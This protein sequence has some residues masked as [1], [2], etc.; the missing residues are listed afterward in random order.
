[1]KT[2]VIGAGF[3][4]LAAA[5]E[6]AKAGHQVVV[7]EKF[8]KAG[9][10][11]AGFSA[12][13]WRWTAEHHYHHIFASDHHV[14]NW[15]ERLELADQV[16]F[17]P[18]VSA[19]YRQKQINRLDSPVS[20]LLHPQLSFM[21]KL[22]TAAGLGFCKLRPNGLSLERWT[23]AEFIQTVMGRESW[24][25]LWQPL[26]AGKF[27][28]AADQ[29]N[30]AWFWA[31]IHTRSQRLGY[32]KGGF[33]RLADLAVKKLFDQGVKF[34]F[35]TKV[36][37]IKQTRSGW[38]LTA[39]PLNSKKTAVNQAGSFYFDQVLFTGHSRELVQ[40]S[41][42]LPDWYQ[43]QLKKLTGLGAVSLLLEL[44]EPLLPDDTYWLNINQ[45][46]WPFLAVVEHTNLVSPDHYGHK[47]LVYAGNY[48]PA[49]DPLYDLDKQELFDRYLPYLRQLNPGY[50]F[51]HNLNGCYL[52]KTEFAQPVVKTN[53]SRIL[54]KTSTPLSGLYWAGI[55]Q[56][57][58]YDRGINYAVKIG[59]E[60]ASLVDESCK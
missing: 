12:D 31:R 32:F 21:A 14:L 18:A 48:L 1:M 58:P 35:Q 13:D 37:R 49:A 50:D 22:R 45:P 24:E 30:A 60:A 40:I 23:A 44:D 11:S 16:E 4:G 55:E 6:L 33:Q 36:S 28:A 52:F 8:K 56:V 3:A 53:H 25:K 10:M 54:P 46:D 20:L 38:E 43:Q 5:D 51:T 27:G 59:R 29:I 17:T 7:W 42:D 19:G 2:A 39:K 9:G 34:Q 26:F 15:V 47:H 57:Y 41:P